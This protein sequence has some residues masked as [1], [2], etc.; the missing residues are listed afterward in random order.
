[1]GTLLKWICALPGDLRVISVPALS[2]A[3]MTNW[4][5]ATLGSDEFSSEIG[6]NLSCA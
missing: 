2:L 5:A 1:M 3:G 4:G 6:G